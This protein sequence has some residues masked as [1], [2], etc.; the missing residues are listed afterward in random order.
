MD[1][2][3]YVQVFSNKSYFAKVYP[4]YSNRKHV[5]TLKLLCQ[6]FGV[7]DKPTF[8]SSKEKAC[9]GTTFKKEVCS[10][11][12]DHHIS[13]TDLQKHNPVEGVI[14]ELRHKWYHSMVNKRVPRKLWDYGVSWVSELI[15]MT[16]YS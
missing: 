1:S 5:D 14:R 8:D 6:Y 9:K 7:P 10:Q 3:H 2:N 16:H 4:M 15:P 11:G 13:D 12:I